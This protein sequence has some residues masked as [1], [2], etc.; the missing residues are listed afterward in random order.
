MLPEEI[1]IFEDERAINKIEINKKLLKK[2]LIG[3]ENFNQLIIGLAKN[4]LRKQNRA[5]LIAI[6]GYQGVNFQ[7]LISNLKRKVE[8]EGIACETIDFSICF[9]HS[10]EIE[11]I[12]NPYITFDP[13]FAKLWVEGNF[14]LLF[15]SNKILEVKNMLKESKMGKDKLVVTF[16]CGSALEELIG[17][18]DYIFYLDITRQEQLRRLDK[19]DVKNL[20][21]ENEEYEASYV[22]KR[23]ICVDHPVTE[24]HKKFVLSKM[25]YYIDANNA[26]NL[27]IIPKNVYDKIISTLVKYPIRL[28]PV[29]IPGIWGGQFLKRVRELP[30]HKKNVAWS[31]E[32]VPYIQSILILLN[33]DITIDL[34]FLNLLWQE[35]ENLLGRYC[36]EMFDFDPYFEIYCWPISFNYDDTIEGGDMSIQCHP[37]Y[38]YI[39]DR[40][41]EPYSH[42][43]SYYVC[44]VAPGSSVHF[45][46]KE[47]INVEEFK[48]L[49][50][51]AEEEKI[52][53]DQDKYVNRFPTKPGDYFLIPAG[54]V[55]GSGKNQVVL[56]IDSN[57]EGVDLTFKIY[58]YLR[59]DLLG[60]LRPIRLQYAWDVV[61]FERT[62]SYV[63]KHLKQEP[64]L[65]RKGKGWAEYIIGKLEKTTTL[66]LFFQTNRLEFDKRIDDRTTDRFHVLTLVE[67]EKVLI[68][69]KKFKERNYLLKFTE[70]IIIPACFGDYMIINKGNIPCKLVKTFV[71]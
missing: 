18:Y 25:N 69:S 48:E 34:P 24:K 63:L 55:H 23:L 50:K 44:W 57:N 13:H 4:F 7:A 5:C 15:E 20:G 3:N 42:D 1:S 56:E 38:P 29:Y 64:I 31:L 16:N 33:K 59:P 46:F 43:E 37:H 14:N 21:A 51:R 60:K 65:L 9:K 26:E 54:T 49:C 67:G 62:T 70:T 32:C 17:L 52:P 39:K 40:F 58:D 41:G 36:M 30:K 6:D 12:V 68:Q 2:V 22:Y 10:K 66:H 28:K 61:R 53:F 47:G 45:G 8:N 35:K 27:K 71:R 11:T 19:G